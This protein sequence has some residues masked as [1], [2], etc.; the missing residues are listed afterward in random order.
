MRRGTTPTHQFVLPF[1]T[2]LITAAEITYCQGDQ[3]ILQKTEEDCV[4]QETLVSITLS[5][6]DTFK[7][8]ENTNVDIQIRVRDKNGTVFASDIM[9]VS[10]QSCL[11]EEVLA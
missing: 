4:M 3:I 9:R 11:S 1:N 7:F 6:Q 2:E 5:Q 10:C 8:K